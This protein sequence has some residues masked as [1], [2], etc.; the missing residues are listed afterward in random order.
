M[1]VISLVQAGIKNVV[2][3]MGTALTKDQARLLKRYVETVYICYDDEFAGQKATIRGLEILKEEGLDVKVI[4]LPDGMDPDD[5]VNKLGADGYRQFI[6][7]A[8]PLIMAARSS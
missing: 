5:A 7:G 6:V 4:S 2:A 1:D 3:S 8:K